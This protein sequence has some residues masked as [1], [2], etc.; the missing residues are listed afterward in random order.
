MIIGK[1]QI[2]SADV[3]KNIAFEIKQK[4]D[5]LALVLAADIAGKPQVTVMFSDNL[6][7]DKDLNAG[8]LVKELA[9]EIKG[10][11]GGQP[12]YATAGGKDVTGLDAV[13]TKAKELF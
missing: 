7:K 4:V 12:F 3:V 2:D 8:K 13:V 10:G 1:I 9:K 5:N 11:G 6:V